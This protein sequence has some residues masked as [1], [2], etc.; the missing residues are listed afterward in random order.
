MKREWILWNV[1][2]APEWIA[3]DE[4]M[5]EIE[6]KGYYG[7]TGFCRAFCMRSWRFCISGIFI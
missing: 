1:L 6:R 3:G 2:C 5:K 7:V 4:R